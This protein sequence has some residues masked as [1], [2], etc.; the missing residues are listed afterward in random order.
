MWKAGYVE[1]LGAVSSTSG[2]AVPSPA[3]SPEP[4]TTAGSASLA[5][6]SSAPPELPPP[7]PSEAPG[8]TESIL[9]SLGIG[10]NADYL[11]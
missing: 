7:P 2:A 6:P 9:N 10:S 5:T 1:M 11:A 4:A 8:T 3:K